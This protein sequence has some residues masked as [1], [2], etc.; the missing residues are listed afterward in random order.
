M[1]FLFLLLACQSSMNRSAWLQDQLYLDNR[2]WLQR[3]PELLSE[4]FRKMSEHSYHFMR[5]T[6]PLY[7][8]DLLRIEPTK[9]QTA[10]LSTPESM[11]IPLYGDPHPENSSVLMRSDGSFDVEFVDLDSATYGPWIFDLRRL[12]TALRLLAL[13]LEGC[14]QACEDE[15]VQAALR[16]MKQAHHNEPFN[17]EDSKIWRDYLD[18]AE[19]EGQERKKFEKYTRLG[20]D[21]HRVI[22]VDET[23]DED[24]EGL[25]GLSQQAYLQVERLSQRFAR[26]HGLEG[27]RMLDAA[28]KYGTGI[29]SRPAI[30]YV[31]LWDNGDTDDQ[32]DVLTQFR[33]ILDAPDIASQAYDNLSFFDNNA[34]RINQ[35]EQELW[36]NPQADP[37]HHGFWDDGHGFKSVSWSSWIQD[38]ER[39]KLIED[40]DE[41]DYGLEEMVELSESLGWIMGRQHTRST[42]AT[43]QPSHLIVQADIQEGGGWARLEAEIVQASFDDAV[44]YQNDFE[45]FQDLLQQKGELLGF[46]KMEGVP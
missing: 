28:R 38:I 40:W 41:G 27:F 16:G 39:D 34:D 43:G 42:S 18:E 11:A 29:S 36:Q 26:K 22:L 31:I 15:L 44:R 2:I 20:D 1:L 8:A 4:K 12:A 46:E 17:F 24:G 3:D 21:G 30:R 5:G 10:F 35:F 6:V 33:E 37:Y 7:Y 9:A 32:D 19:E 45:L 25:L 13:Q 14:E 23:L